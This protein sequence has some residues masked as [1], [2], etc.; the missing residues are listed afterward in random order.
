MR[1]CEVRSARLPGECGIRIVLVSDDAPISLSVAGSLVRKR[2]VTVIVKVTDVRRRPVKGA[3]VRVS[4]SVHAKPRRSGKQ[5][6]VRFVERYG[7]GQLPEPDKIL[8][9]VKKL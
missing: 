2:R 6:K 4:G 9:E 5:G 3:V 8:S 7:K 1:I